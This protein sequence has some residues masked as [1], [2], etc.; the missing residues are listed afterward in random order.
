ML[1]MNLVLVKGLNVM[2]HTTQWPPN[3]EADETKRRTLLDW[4]EDPEMRP[5][6][7]HRLP[8]GEVKEALRVM[9][10]REMVGRVVLCPQEV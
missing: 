4:A 8:L 6:I 3:P 9:A 1:P 10:Y 7:S 5:H 2:A